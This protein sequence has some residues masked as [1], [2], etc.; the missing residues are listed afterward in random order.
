MISEVANRW[1]VPGEDVVRLLRKKKLQVLTY[2]YDLGDGWAMDVPETSVAL[3]ERLYGKEIARARRRHQQ[4]VLAMEQL[5][6][7]L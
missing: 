6:L 4:S 5:M 7:D 2:A 3:A 1:I